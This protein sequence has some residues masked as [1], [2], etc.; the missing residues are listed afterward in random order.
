MAFVSMRAAPPTRRHLRHWERVCCC[1]D[2]QPYRAVSLPLSADPPISVRQFKRMA[3]FRLL[4]HRDDCRWQ[5]S[6]RWRAILQRLW[7]RLPPGE[8]TSEGAASPH[9]D[10]VPFIV[11]TGVD[12]LYVNLEAHEG[13]PTA[14]VDGCN[15]LKA[16]AQDAI[17]AALT[18]LPRVRH[19]LA[20]V[21]AELF[22]QL[23]L[24][25]V[26]RGEYLETT[27]TLSQELHAFANEQDEADAKRWRDFAEEVCEKARML[28]KPVPVRPVSIGAKWIHGVGIREGHLNDRNSPPQASGL[29][30]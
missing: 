2:A 18:R 22:G 25:A 23:M 5:L 26:L 3:V 10:Q 20:Q 28:G 17:P 27:A 9:A 19:D 6:P 7:D 4:R 15:A 14:L 11:D 21:D 16:L 29:Q 30:P 12:T 8:P 13:L 24:R 1:L